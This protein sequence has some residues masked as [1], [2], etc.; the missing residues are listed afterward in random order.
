MRYGLLCGLWVSMAQKNK[1]WT[2]LSFD[3]QS[4]DLL[5]DCMAWRFW[6]MI[7]SN[8]CSTSALRS[9]AAKQWSEEL[10]QKKNGRFALA[11]AGAPFAPMQ[12]ASNNKDSHSTRFFETLPD[13]ALR[14]V[15]RC[16]VTR[17]KLHTVVASNSRDHTPCSLIDGCVVV[18]V[19]CKCCRK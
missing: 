6:T 7:Q 12:R 13:C 1:P 4:I 15:T 18:C 16:A 17:A 11:T 14:Y 19:T 10:A 5:M 3:V 2:M 8:G 9:S